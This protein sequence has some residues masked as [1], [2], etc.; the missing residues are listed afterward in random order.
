[1]A[2]TIDHVTKIISIPK[3]DLTLE[4]GTIYSMDSDAFRLALKDWE[5]S[6]A[7]MP[8]PDTHRHN[9]EVTVSGT[10]Y[11]RTIEII[12]GYSLEFEDGQY[13]VIIQ[14]SNNNFHDVLNGILQQNQVQIIP[15]NSAGYI[16]VETGVSGLT[17]TESQQLEDAY[18]EAAAAN[19][20]AGNAETAASSA[21]TNAADAET[22]ALAAET[23]ANNADTNTLATKAV[24]DFLNKLETNRAVIVNEGDGS[25]TITIYDDDNVTPIHVHTVNIT[26]TERMPV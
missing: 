6:E 8:M 25:Q 19:V 18:T 2:F 3:A 11:V 24:I 5:D 12:N 4:S 22:A 7:G 9:T 14:G 21:A 15:S 26:R 13:T 10:T 1:M 20:S 23:A 17:P 16:T